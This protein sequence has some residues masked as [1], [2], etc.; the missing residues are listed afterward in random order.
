MGYS[1]LAVEVNSEVMKANVRSTGRLAHNGP[2]GSG[3]THIHREA[4]CQPARRV[5]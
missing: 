4:C 5:P 2:G 1:G 3:G